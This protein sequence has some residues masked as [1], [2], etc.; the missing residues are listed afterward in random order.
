MSKFDRTQIMRRAWSIFRETYKYPA[1]KFASI[2][3]KCFGWCLREAWRQARQAAALAAIP[4]DVRAA[5]I[6]T[7]QRS[8]ELEQFND[9]WPQAKANLARMHAEIQQLSA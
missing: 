3:R 2:G 9:C 7:L 5:R 8:I 1:I 6:E 4:A